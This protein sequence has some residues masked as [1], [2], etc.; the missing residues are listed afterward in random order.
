MLVF[1]WKIVS[2]ANYFVIYFKNYLGTGSLIC[3]RQVVATGSLDM[4]LISFVYK[5]LETEL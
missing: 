4:T 2:I 5:S 1:H 3:K